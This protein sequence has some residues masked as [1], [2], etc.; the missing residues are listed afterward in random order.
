MFIRRL[1]PLLDVE[2]LGR[3]DVLEVDAAEG[4]LEQLHATDELLGV[5][6][7]DS[8]SNTSM[9]AKRLKRTPF[10]SITGLPASG[11]DVPSPS[12]AVPLVMTATRLPLA[13]YL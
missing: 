3:G 9:S 12:T 2:A 6:R 13:V 4:R 7:V 1:Q 11:A 5:A 10:P 8:R